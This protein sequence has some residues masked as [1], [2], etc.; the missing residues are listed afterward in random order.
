VGPSSATQPPDTAA[1]TFRPREA[2]FSQSASL[3]QITWTGRYP[4]ASQFS[5]PTEAVPPQLHSHVHSGATG[6]FSWPEG[7]RAQM[8]ECTQ[9]LLL[10]GKADVCFYVSRVLECQQNLE[11]VPMHPRP[12]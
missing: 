9:E 3:R 7:S 6:S 2:H 11:H 5:K 10:G 12:T 8:S 1:G 4:P